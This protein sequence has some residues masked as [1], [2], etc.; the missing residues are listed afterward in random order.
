LA[1]SRAFGQLASRYTSGFRQKWLV[2][3]APS[4][5]PL[6]GSGDIQSLADLAN[7]YEVVRSMRAVPFDKGLVV[8][9]A[10]LIALPLLPLTLTMIPLEELAERLIKLLL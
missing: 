4:D 8:R 5:E 2:G 9:L 6:L 1:A 10:I 3:G 7:S